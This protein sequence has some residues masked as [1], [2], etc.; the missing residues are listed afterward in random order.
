MRI[1]VFAVCTDAELRQLMV[2]QRETIITLA[3]TKN[4]EYQLLD[5]VDKLPKGCALQSVNQHCNVYILVRGMVDLDAEIEKLRVKS[6]KTALTRDQIMK[7]MNMDE[8]ETRVRADVR[9]TDAA[10]VS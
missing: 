10:R 2:E 6:E 9:E 3:F 1:I 7:K 4:L 5:S 8:Y